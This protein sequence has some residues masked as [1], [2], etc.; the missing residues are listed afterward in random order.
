MYREI[1]PDMV[2]FLDEKLERNG[3]AKHATE[4]GDARTLF[5]LAAEACVGIVEK[6][7]NSGPMVSLIQDTV[8]GQDHVPWCM[9]LVQTCLAYAE[10]KTGKKS[11]IYVSE[12]CLS[13]WNKTK[14]EQRVK[15]TPLPGAIIIW[16]HGKSMSGHVGIV[17]GCDEKL[18]LTVEGN[19]SSDNTKVQREGDGVYFKNR[20]KFSQGS[21]KVLGYLKPF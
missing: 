9:S 2:K 8:G 20:S 6:G 14:E 4:E 10:V 21:M 1:H 16:Q 18:V 5:V 11:P 15:L 19:T 7:A 3:L 12:H 17:R 13:V